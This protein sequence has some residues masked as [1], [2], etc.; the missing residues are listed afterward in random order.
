[1]G[2]EALLDSTAV[3]SRIPSALYYP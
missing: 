2:G 3:Y 1:M